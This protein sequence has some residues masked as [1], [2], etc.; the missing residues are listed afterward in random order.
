MILTLDLK[1]LKSIKSRK[2]PTCKHAFDGVAGAHPCSL[3]APGVGLNRP[4]LRLLSFSPVP[5]FSCRPRE[6][7]S[8]ASRGQK[9]TAIVTGTFQILSQ[10]RPGEGAPLKQRRLR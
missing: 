5:S 2:S 4:G 9:W 7:G 6:P 8:G 1:Q 10:N 3:A